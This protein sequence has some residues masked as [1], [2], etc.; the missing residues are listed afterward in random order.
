MSCFVSWSSRLQVDVAYLI[1]HCLRVVGVVVV[2][3][4]GEVVADL[5]PL[6][7]TI[8]SPSS[9]MRSFSPSFSSRAFVIKDMFL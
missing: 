9:S 5:L 8:S 2:E 1:L 6:S 3:E 7:N 4:V